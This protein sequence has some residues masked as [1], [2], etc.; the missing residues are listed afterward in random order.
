MGD[1][2]MTPL[3]CIWSKIWGTPGEGLKGRSCE[4]HTAARGGVLGEGDLPFPPA[5][6]LEEHCKL[7]HWGPAT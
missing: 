7:P 6:G 2:P 4:A 1:W 5:R 3:P